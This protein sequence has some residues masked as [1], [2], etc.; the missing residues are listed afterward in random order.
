MQKEKNKGFNGKVYP[1]DTSPE[2][3]EKVRNKFKDID[4][5]EIPISGAQL[6]AKI[7]KEHKI[8]SL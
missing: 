4:H 3:M 8:V 2:T 5:I 6:L 7:R 1:V